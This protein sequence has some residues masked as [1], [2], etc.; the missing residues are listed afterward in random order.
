MTAKITK[1][2]ARDKA[3]VGGGSG[4]TTNGEFETITVK[5]TATICEIENEQIANIETRI[6]AIEDKPADGLPFEDGLN[7]FIVNADTL[8]TFETNDD[9]V[10]EISFETSTDYE[11]E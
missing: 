6:K 7:D 4:S 11:G 3:L 9:N 5:Q 10:L 2:K 8:K 1:N